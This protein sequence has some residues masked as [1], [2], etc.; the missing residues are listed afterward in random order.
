[1]L[2]LLIEPFRAAHRQRLPVIAIC[3]FQLIY[4]FE[5]NTNWMATALSLMIKVILCQAKNHHDI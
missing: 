1:M 3:I 2:N 4:V 5:N